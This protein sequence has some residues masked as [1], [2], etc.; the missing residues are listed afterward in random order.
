MVRQIAPCPASVLKT[1]VHTSFSGGFSLFP[2]QR[3]MS[4]DTSLPAV[5]N[6]TLEVVLCPS[7]SPIL[8]VSWPCCPGQRPFPSFGDKDVPSAHLCGAQQDDD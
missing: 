4:F 7:H 8:A 6:S 1:Q 3:A 2:S 5:F